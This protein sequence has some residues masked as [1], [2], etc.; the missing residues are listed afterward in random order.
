M[1]PYKVLEID[2]NASKEEIK[3][4][5]H[6]LARKYHPDR[7]NTTENEEKFKKINEAYFILNNGGSKNQAF[8]GNYGDDV[9]SIF[10]KFKDMDFTKIS[11]RLYSEVKH[12]Q[13]FFNEKHPDNTGCE[14]QKDTMDDIVVNAKI[15]IRDIYYNLEKS[16]SL[17]KKIKCREC[18]G[19]GTIT[20]NIICSEC[21]GT[22][23]KEKTVNLKIES[24][25]LNHIFFKQGDEHISKYTGNI[26][27][28]VIPKELN[29]S[30]IKIFTESDIQLEFLY[31]DII[32]SYDLLIQIEKEKIPVRTTYLKIKIL[33]QSFIK[34]D[35]PINIRR[36]KIESLGLINPSKFMRGDIFIQLI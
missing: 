25:K 30:F 12:F 31:L 15:D 28:N 33:E 26:V 5:Y 6:R 1:D 24:A 13:K 18:M 7:N 11:Q 35:I 29:N 19:L 4:A 27:V 21:N 16:F 36:V 32:N 23:Y 8:G 2:K 9:D 10:Q 14:N 17:K 22:R 3:K 20:N 34:I